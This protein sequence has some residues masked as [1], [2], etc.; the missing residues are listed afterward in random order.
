MTSAVVAVA[1]AVAAAAVVK[2]VAVVPKHEHAPQHRQSNVY[3]S[4]FAIVLNSTEDDE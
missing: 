2:L 3:L 4:F 1:S